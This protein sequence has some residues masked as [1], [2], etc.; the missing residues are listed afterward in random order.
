MLQGLGVTQGSLCIND[1]LTGLM[2]PDL[3]R[4]G[5]HAARRSNLYCEFITARLREP[6]DLLHPAVHHLQQRWRKR[7]KN[8]QSLHEGI[9]SVSVA[10]EDL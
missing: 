6:L 2:E 9:F 1:S 10:Q 7:R 4:R 8:K 3:Q 5:A